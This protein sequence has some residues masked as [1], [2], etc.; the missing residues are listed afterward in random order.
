MLV[1]ARSIGCVK[2][3][4]HFSTGSRECVF[5]AAWIER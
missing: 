4:D 3:G 1:F 2:R 5:N